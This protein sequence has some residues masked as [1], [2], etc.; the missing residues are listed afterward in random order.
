[1]EPLLLVEDKS[2]LRAMLHKAL[3]AVPG[4]KCI[5]NY[6]ADYPALG[7]EALSGPDRG[8]RMPFEAVAGAMQARLGYAGR[9]EYVVNY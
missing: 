4:S 7:G 9:P 6:G 5:T 3:S 1:M 8:G 2:E